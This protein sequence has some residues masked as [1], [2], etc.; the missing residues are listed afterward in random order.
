MFTP[1]DGITQHEQGILGG[2]V[3]LLQEQLQLGKG[4][5]VQIRG[6]INHGIHSFTNGWMYL[7]NIKMC[8]KQ[9][10]SSKNP[11]FRAGFRCL[12]VFLQTIQQLFIRTFKARLVA[13][14][15]LLIKA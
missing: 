12:S 10:F 7:Y 1:V 8:E 14:A 3:G 15:H 5:P 11:L 2:K 6:H 13:V 4:N 9:G